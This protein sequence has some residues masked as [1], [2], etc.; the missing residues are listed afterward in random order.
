MRQPGTQGALLWHILAPVTCPSCPGLRHPHLQ[1]GAAVRTPTDLGRADPQEQQP[2]GDGMIV[3][4]VCQPVA[5]AAD[6]N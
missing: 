5:Y 2:L 3:M 1:L 6:M 4:A